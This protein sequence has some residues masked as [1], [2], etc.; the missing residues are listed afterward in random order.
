MKTLFTLL[1][2]LLVTNSYADDYQD[3]RSALSRLLPGLT[4]YEIRPAAIDN[5]LEVRADTS[6]FYVSSDGEFL[7][8]GPLYRLE[9]GE[10]L[11][12]KRLALY[13]KNLVE[14][15]PA[16]MPI[17]YPASNSRHRVTVITDIDCPYCRQ[18]H[19][20]MDAYHAAGLDIEYLML[21]RAGKDSPSYIK[22]VHAVCAEQPGEAITAAMNG[23]I[24]APANCEHSVDQHMA[25][26]RSLGVS[27]T[28]NILLVDGTL[29]R[30]YKTAAELAQILDAATA[31]T[32]IDQ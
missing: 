8:N 29:I 4:D 16:L 2:A 24:P 31:T 13:R 28:P 3:I 12:E 11:T 1:L 22:T 15:I 26:A 14:D 20:D 9:Q 18:L 23:E 6:V 30:G 27:S 25:M 19:Q 32:Q 21:P 17:E 5:L 10:N 7:L